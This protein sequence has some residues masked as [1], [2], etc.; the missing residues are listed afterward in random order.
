[1]AAQLQSESGELVSMALVRHMLDLTAWQGQAPGQVLTAAGLTAADIADPDGWLPV[2]YGGRMIR[3]VLAGSGDP[4]FYLRLSQLTFLSGYGIVGYLLESSPTLHDAIQS[5]MR[6]ERLISTV[7]YSKL[8]HL[9][10][11]ALWSFECRHADPVVVRHMTEFHSGCRYL[12]MHMVKEK[13]SRIVSE[14]HFRHEGPASARE[15]EAYEQVFRCPVRFGQPR[16]ALVLR[17]SALALPLRQVEFGLKASLEAHADRKLMAMMREQESLREQARAQLRMLLLG[18]H[19]TRERLA[20]RLGISARHLHR[21]LQAEDSSYRELLDELRLELARQRLRESTRTIEDVGRLLGF[22]EG[23]SF[24]R[25]FRQRT[26]QTPGD[27]R[28][29][30][31]ES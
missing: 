5:L 21:Q 22:T 28:Q 13:R 8:E 27:F 9:P 26:G 10:G 11:R 20:E 4:Q 25:W 19:P 23:Q 29:R 6:Y 17:Q 24:T 15:V 14:V 7:I 30:Q 12:F 3:A 2:E 31:G 18:G 16:S 1:M